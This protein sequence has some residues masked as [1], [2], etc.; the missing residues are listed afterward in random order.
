MLGE[1]VKQMNSVPTFK[2]YYSEIHFN[3]ILRST[4][5]D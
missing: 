2:T 4:H 1:Q 3:I 5:L